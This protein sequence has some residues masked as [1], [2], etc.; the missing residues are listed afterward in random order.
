ML[1][2]E[3]L[4]T[5]MPEFGYRKLMMLTVLIMAV[6]V[7]ATERLIPTCPRRVPGVTQA[8][9]MLIP[10]VSKAYPRLVLGTLL[11]FHL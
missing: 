5:S 4:F 8:Y 10:G 9:P 7:V 2:L 11:L 1:F 3:F 6:V